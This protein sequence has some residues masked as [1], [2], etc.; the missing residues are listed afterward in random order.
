MWKSQASFIFGVTQGSALPP[1]SKPE[2]AFWGRSNVGKSSLIN[3]LCNNGKLAKTSQTPGRTRQMNFFDLPGLL[4]IVDL[5]GYGYAKVPNKEIYMWQKL[6]VDYA[7]TRNTLKAF[8]I[9]IDGRHGVKKNDH[10]MMTML[11]KIPVRYD[12][13]VNKIDEVPLK[14]R[15][16]LINSVALDLK[17]HGAAFPTFVCTSGHTKEGIGELQKLI[18]SKIRL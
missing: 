4:H 2:V 11:D 13:I 17:K 18:S 15:E 3:A 6:I 12:I 9:I 14:D 16:A 5:P 7:M 8:F 1:E 10:E